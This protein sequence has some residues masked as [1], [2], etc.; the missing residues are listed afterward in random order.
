MGHIYAPGPYY[1]RIRTFLREYQPP[2]IA[3]AR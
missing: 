3:M 1:Q 2:K